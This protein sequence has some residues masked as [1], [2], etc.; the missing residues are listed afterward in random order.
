MSGNELPLQACQ[1]LFSFGRRQPNVGN[2]AD[3]I[4]TVDLH[5]VDP[6]F[7]NVIPGFHQPYNP[8][9]ASVPDQRPNAK[10]PF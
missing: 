2:I 9:H 4:G 10:I 5:D 8:S 7:L 3:I 1:H 6:L